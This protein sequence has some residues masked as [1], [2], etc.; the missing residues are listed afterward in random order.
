M[1]AARSRPVHAPAVVLAILAVLVGSG[2]AFYQFSPWP[3]AMLLRSA[4][5][6]DGRRTNADILPRVPDGIVARLDIPYHPGDRDATL[7][8]YHPPDTT[9]PL[10][11]VVWVHGGAFVGGD[12]SYISNYLRT[13][14]GSGLTVIGI[15]Y[16][17]APGA[18][19]PTPVAQL[20]QALAFVMQ[21]ADSLHVD[22]ARL[23]LAGDSAGAQIVSQYACM[24]TDPEY[25]RRL[26]VQ[27]VVAPP[28]RGLILCCGVYDAS[29]AKQR[30]D[31]GNLLKT[32]LWAY[33]GKRDFADDER[34]ALLSTI[35]DVNAAFP[36]VFITSGRVDPLAP[37]SHAMADRLAS[38]GVDV[39]TLFFGPD[40]QPPPPHE[41]QFNLFTMAG[42]EAFARITAF[43]GSH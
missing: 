16:S 39:D 13:L 7:D 30:G 25:A 14:A 34:F 43:I 20:G 26:G 36:P 23:F 11:T 40:H 31:L 29:A 24:T 41:Y 19:Y 18:H 12:K 32:V 28:F 35:N 42:L 9:T 17:L 1:R 37:Q 10:P 5:A 3:S 4:F 27:P 33:S 8:L 15:N 6:K 22:P 38:L 2:F 21:R